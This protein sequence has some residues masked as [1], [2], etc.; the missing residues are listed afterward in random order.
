MQ[1]LSGEALSFFK[2]GEKLNAR[3]N[4]AIRGSQQRL[5][6]V[7]SGFA[8]ESSGEAWRSWSA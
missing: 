3:F 1:P 2:M 7:I 5:S 6:R 8:A 4:A